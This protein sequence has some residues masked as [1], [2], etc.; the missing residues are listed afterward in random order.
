MPLG[1]RLRIGSTALRSKSLVLKFKADFPDGF[2]REFYGR[3]SYENRR[4]D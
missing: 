1:E 3:F 2:K 4:F